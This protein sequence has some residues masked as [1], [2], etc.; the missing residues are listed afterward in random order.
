M[1]TYVL[2]LGFF[3][4]QNGSGARVDEGPRRRLV[5][6]TESGHLEDYFPFPIVTATNFLASDGIVASPGVALPPQSA[7]TRNEP[8]PPPPPPPQQQQQKQQHHQRVQSLQP[9]SPFQQYQQQHQFQQQLQNFQLRSAAERVQPRGSEAVNPASVDTV[10]ATLLALARLPTPKLRQMLN[11]TASGGGRDAFSLSALRV[12]RCPAVPAADPTLNWLPPL[13]D[14]APAL[15]FRSR[16]KLDAGGT[17]KRSGG[18]GN[19]GGSSDGGSDVVSEPSKPAMLW[20]EHLSKAGGTSFCK[21]AMKNMPRKEVPSYYCMPSEPGMPDARVGQWTND[22]LGAY[23]LRERHTLVSNEWEPFPLQRLEMGQGKHGQIPLDLVLVTTIREPLN[24]LVSAYKFWGVLHNQNRNKPHLQRWLKNM[25]ARARND[26]ASPRGI[27][28]GPGS[29]RD[30]I[31]QVG[32]PNFA[33]W[34]F[35]GGAL[36]VPPERRIEKMKLAAAAGKRVREEEVVWLEPFET[37]VR[38]LCRFDLAIPMEELSGHTQPL[39]DLLGWSHFEDTHFVPSGNVVNNDAAAELS[40]ADFVLLWEV[41]KLDMVLYHWVRAVYL[42]RIH[43]LIGANHS[44]YH[45][46]PRSTV[47][48][49]AG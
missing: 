14:S 43:C 19:G 15:H 36:T 47:D 44:S 20:Y 42:A 35:S 21:L 3:I 7:V 28:R 29:G 27:G 49:G 12:G 9:P 5:P 37:A 31:A 34:K 6:A 45:K 46:A 13:Q 11:N 2:V 25:E 38:T 39:A 41:N 26:A 30:F 32:R 23:F 40:P 24:R 10:V 8:S 16:H 18:A 48:A 17:R 1:L 22:K 33:T 4:R